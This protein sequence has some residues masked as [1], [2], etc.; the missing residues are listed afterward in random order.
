MVERVPES[1]A[2]DDPLFAAGQLGELFVIILG[3]VRAYCQDAEGDHGSAERSSKPVT[4]TSDVASEAKQQQEWSESSSKQ[5]TVR[6]LPASGS[7]APATSQRS[8]QK[9]R[10]ETQQ[11]RT[12][13]KQGWN[14]VV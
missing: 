12:E 3:V 14:L 7:A 9:Q 2:Q 6:H 8:R 4:H 10:K 1:A 11:S 13:D 5:P